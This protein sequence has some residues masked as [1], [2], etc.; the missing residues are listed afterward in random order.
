MI[1]TGSR[2]RRR[3]AVTTA[4]LTLGLAGLT[5]GS[6]AAG[7][8]APAPPAPAAAS[9]GQGAL[10]MTT[11]C[12][13]PAGCDLYASAGSTTLGGASMTT[14]GFTAD[15]SAP[16]APGGPTLVV[17]QDASV[18][19]KL[20]NRLPAS[21]GA[22]AL[23]VPALLNADTTGVAAG[24]DSTYTFTA[25][26][27]GTYLYEAGP[28]PGGTT[29][30]AK[31]VAMGLYGALVVEPTGGQS[32][33]D[34][35]VLLLSE[36]DSRLAANPAGFTMSNWAPLYRLVNGAVA[37]NSPVV[38][39]NAG[40]TV[41]LRYLN[42]GLEDH[43][44]G[45]LGLR[46]TLHTQDARPIADRSVV[47][48][49]VAPG[50]SL[51]ATVALPG[52]SDGQRFPIYEANN[53][54]YAPAASSGGAGGGSLS[55]GGMLTYLQSGTPQQTCSGPAATR[56]TID[57]SSVG[58]LGSFV[59]GAH[60]DAC[61][62]SAT[63]TAAGYTL[64][65]ADPAGVTPIPVPTDNGSGV[66]V[67]AT[68]DLSALAAQPSSGMH[69]VFIFGQDSTGAWGA[70]TTVLIY[71]DSDGPTVS[72]LA[73]TPDIANGA[74]TVEV[75]ADATDNAT[76][77]NGVQSAS[78]C[79]DR[80]TSGSCAASYPMAVAGTSVP[81]LY[82]LSVTLPTLTNGTHNVD[83]S[84]VDGLGNV[85]PYA[86]A[87]LLVDTI[88]PGPAPE[89]GAGS[90]QVTPNNGTIPLSSGSAAVRVDG[91]FQDPA[92]PGPASNVVAAEMFVDN[93]PRTN[94][95]GVTML[96]T[97]LFNSPTEGAYALI[98]L[99][100]IAAMTQGKHLAWVHA[101]DA[102]GNWGTP[103]SLPF[104]V[105][106]SAPTGTL[107]TATPY[108]P[109]LRPQTL[110]LRAVMTDP[111]NTSG[112]APATD[113]VASDVTSMEYWINTDPGV[114]NGRPLALGATP[115]ST[116]DVTFSI[117]LGGITPG[118]NTFYVRSQ[119]S[120]GNWSLPVSVTVTNMQKPNGIFANS[121][122]VLGSTQGWATAVGGARLTV[123]NAPGMVPYSLA[124]RL[125][126]AAATYVTDTT[127]VLDT[128]YNAKFEFNPN[129]A[130][131]GAAGQRIFQ[132]L[133]ATNQQVFAVTVRR[134]AA[135]LYQVSGTA[136]NGVANPV[137]PWFTITNV[138]HVIEVG[139]TAVGGAGARNLKLY[140][141]GVLK[142]TVATPNNFGRSIES[143]RLGATGGMPA[144]SSGTE[145]FDSFVSTRSGRP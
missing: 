106:H 6:S 7:G 117:D 21:A 92:T 40:K 107:T 98:P 85:G 28:G 74:I 89:I 81:G 144:G 119:D 133:T 36:F 53:A 134:T 22:L 121:F 132:G 19:V 59:I 16:T 70:P 79:L 111:A 17:P 108:V 47:A 8:I 44:M 82:G 76:G 93:Q 97:G 140:V 63:V 33:D 34:E 51:D 31:Q 68:V 130:R 3:S 55:Y 29:D 128:I 145:Y 13:T 42:A 49:T 135:G 35:A 30:Q 11:A 57:R 10:P 141:D 64:D 114:G 24:G 122:S 84:A 110:N 5:V 86:S 15:N 23:N 61:A 109:A 54:V 78:V 83:V 80:G 77:G 116:E 46:Q 66:D 94:G 131:M 88:A 125:A 71:V 139:W 105:D 14:W 52:N 2:S 9:A 101:K 37:P 123:V 143:V 48:E 104:V 127:P 65:N 18:T 67:T 103:A 41:L 112:G 118:P 75:T 142:A 43:S 27:P 87:S 120:A 58:A 45:I 90:V 136:V 32:A 12:T 115:S 39:S 137:S 25:S 38:Q 26:R 69:T 129:G 95:T 60:L 1:T 62:G 102:A 72:S 50:Q 100:Q 113:A 20:H 73:V 4:A 91:L 124:T 99:S 96:P 138:T 126:G 56:P